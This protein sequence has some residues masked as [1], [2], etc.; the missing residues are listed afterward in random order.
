MIFG[1]TFFPTPQLENSWT[2]CCRRKTNSCLN[3]Q[4][5]SCSYSEESS[6]LHVMHTDKRQGLCASVLFTVYLTP[7]GPV[8]TM[9]QHFEC[10]HRKWCKHTP[11]ALK[12]IFVI[13]SGSN[14]HTHTL[15]PYCVPLI[16]IPETQTQFQTDPGRMWVGGGEG[17]LGPLKLRCSLRFFGWEGEVGLRL[18]SP[19][20]R[21]HITKRKWP[22]W[23]LPQTHTT[24]WFAYSIHML[25]KVFHWSSTQYSF[26]ARRKTPNNK[27]LFTRHQVINIFNSK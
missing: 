15:S 11:S 7:C 26:T 8:Q 17:G 9:I 23:L 16:Q 27:T 6:W 19:P 25:S 13:S 18:W 1:F 24:L 20:S 5:T 10:Q 12:C 22:D 3:Y 21:I 4:S 14:S 2:A